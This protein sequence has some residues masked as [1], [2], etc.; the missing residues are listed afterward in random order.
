[1]ALLF[2]C[3][4]VWSQQD[5]F[6]DSIPEEKPVKKVSIFPLPLISV[7]PTVGFMGGIATS[8]NFFMADP[9]TTSMSTAIPVILFTTKKQ[10]F[11]SIRSNAFLKDDSWVIMLDTRFN[12]NNQPTFGLGS[13]IDEFAAA[14]PSSPGETALRKEVVYFDMFRFYGTALKRYQKTR[15][16]YG[17]GFL[18]DSMYSIEDEGSDQL[19]VPPTNTFHQEYQANKNIDPEKYRQSG[20]SANTMWDSRDN[21][22]NPYTG[23]FTWV[24][25]RAFP[26]W[27]GSTGT[28]SQLWM[29]HRN[30]INLNKDRPRHILAMWTYAWLVTSGDVPYMFL[31]ALG[32]DMFNR[33][34]RPYTFGRFRGH[35]LVYGELEWRFPLQRQ[36]DRFGGIVFLNTTTA[37][38]RLEDISLFDYMQYGYGMGLRYMVIPQKRINLGVDYGWGAAGASGLFI[39]INEFF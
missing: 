19:L 22:A 27:M 21:I 9:A 29:E 4:L 33:S 38:N 17:L 23:S 35:D 16:F 11:T 20:F 37:S 3:A 39:T 6:L 26:E 34:G 5:N 30:Y 13:R 1:M 31:P 28:T 12:I 15:F 8:I 7:N 24:A 25:W 36:K 10:F 18:F 32:W 2:Q 14:D